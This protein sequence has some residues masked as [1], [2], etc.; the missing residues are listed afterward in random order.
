MG[1]YK[2]TGRP[3]GGHC[4]HI[5]AITEL[6]IAAHLIAF[7]WTVFRALSPAASCDLMALTKSGKP[8]RIECTSARYR[9]GIL[10]FTPHDPTRYDLICGI[11][12][13]TQELVF[14]RP[15]ESFE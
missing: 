8:V 1:I 7:G 5:G 12:T 14:A 3:S 15:L 10:H 13:E 2:P 11:H 9:K 4:T 6:R